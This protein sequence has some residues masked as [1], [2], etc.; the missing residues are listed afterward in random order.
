MVVSCG[1]ASAATVQN[2]QPSK[3]CGLMLIEDVVNHPS[4]VEDTDTTWRNDSEA[5]LIYAYIRTNIWSFNGHDWHDGSGSNIVTATFHQEL[6]QF[7]EYGNWTTNDMRFLDYVDTN[8]DYRSPYTPPVPK[9]FYAYYDVTT[10]TSSVLPSTNSVQQRIESRGYVVNQYQ[11]YYH[12]KLMSGNRGIVDSQVLHELCGYADHNNNTPWQA[13]DYHRLPAKA[14]RVG[15]DTLHDD[16][17][18]SNA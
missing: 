5:D 15:K 13:P 4:K 1:M 7:D 11:E 8:I 10:N 2:P 9:S 6:Y 18:F 3:P 16:P 17:N 12:W 14:L